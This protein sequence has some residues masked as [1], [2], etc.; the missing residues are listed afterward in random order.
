MEFT[1][2]LFGPSA[3]AAGAPSVTVTI[4]GEVTCGLL[5]RMLGQRYPSLAPMVKGGRLAVNH[6]FAG[7][8]QRVRPSD[9]IALIAMVGG[10]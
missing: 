7:D 1:V 5:R 9:E 4:E 2:R 6:A 3:D 8:A 10:G